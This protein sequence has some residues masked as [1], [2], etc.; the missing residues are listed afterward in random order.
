MLVY[1]SMYFSFLNEMLHNL[2]L[3][4]AH[5]ILKLAFLH[6]NIRMKF[7]M[8]QSSQKQHLHNDFNSFLNL[9]YQEQG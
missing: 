6:L 7:Q 5:F 1:N 2:T 3:T 4:H 9:N 8:T